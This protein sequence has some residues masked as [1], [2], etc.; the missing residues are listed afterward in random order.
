MGGQIKFINRGKLVEYLDEELR[1]FFNE[2]CIYE[3]NQYG[4]LSDGKHDPEYLGHAMWQDHPPEA[5]ELVSLG[6][7]FSCLMRSA[8][9]SLGLAF[10]Y[11]DATTDALVD[12]AGYAYSYYHADTLNKLHLAADR[13]RDFFVTSFMQGVYAD[14]AMTPVGK[15]I[16]DIV[17]SD[18][19]Q[20]P[21]KHVHDDVV[22]GCCVSNRALQECLSSLLPLVEVVASRRSVNQTPFRYMNQFHNRV[23]AVV[24]NLAMGYPDEALAADLAWEKD[25]SSCELID[26]YA[27]LVKISNHVFMAT[28]LARNLTAQVRNQPVSPRKRR[29]S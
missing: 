21:F 8:R 19:F 25:H 22:A 29:S 5:E 28:H 7:E 18:K 10:L 3:I 27:A 2:N 4:W 9:H 13:I 17:G 23:N 11:R 12:D 24:A 6:E 14:G 15:A 20:L 1:Q 26:W 16:G